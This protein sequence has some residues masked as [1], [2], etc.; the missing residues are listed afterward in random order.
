MILKRTLALTLLLVTVVP[1]AA[2]ADGFIIP[3]VGVNFAGDSGKELSDAADAK[4]FDWGAS[5]AYMGGGVFGAE[6]DV[7]YSPDFFGKTDVGG[8]SVLTLTGNLLLGVPIGGQQGFGIRPYG[9]VGLGLIRTDVNAFGDVFDL[10]NTNGA[11]DFGAGVMLFFGHVGVRG[12]VRYFRTLG[13]VNFDVLK[14]DESLD[15]ARGSLG[16]IIRF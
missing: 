13:D 7:G 4:R 12:E 15:F 2:R 16:F 9:L 3:F 8:S 10:D 5:F 6:A 1:R 11:W 14:S